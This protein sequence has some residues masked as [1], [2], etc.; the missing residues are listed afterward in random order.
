MASHVRVSSF[1]SV[2]V[3]GLLKLHCFTRSFFP[4]F[5]LCCV[6]LYTCVLSSVVLFGV[7]VGRKNIKNDEAHAHLCG[8]GKPQ[9][10]GGWSKP[11]LVGFAPLS[12]K[13]TRGEPFCWGKPRLVGVSPVW[14]G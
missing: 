11:Q 7:V 13:S 10:G 12:C 1:V 14:L 8:W 9:F 6:R 2:F 4:A 5:C 3:S